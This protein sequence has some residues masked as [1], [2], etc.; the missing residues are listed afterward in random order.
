MSIFTKIPGLAGMKPLFC[1]QVAGLFQNKQVCK[2]SSKYTM[3]EWAFA[4]TDHDP[5]DG[6]SAKPRP[7]KMLLLIPVGRQC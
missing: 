5:P 6:C 1:I 3:W 4:L 7:S 2:V